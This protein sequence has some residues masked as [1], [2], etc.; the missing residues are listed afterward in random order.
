MANKYTTV[1]G[2]GLKDGTTWANAFGLAEYLVDFLNS[3][4]PGDIYYVF[5]G[6]YTMS[7]FNWT[8][9]DGNA[10]DFIK[11]VG[12]SD[13]TLLTE[14]QGDD[15]PL[16]DMGAF[17]MLFDDYWEIRNIRATGSNSAY[18][19]RGDTYATFVNCK[20][21]NTGLGE[22]FEGGAVFLRLI[23][24]EASVDGAT[25]SVSLGGN[26]GFFWGNYFHDSTT[27]LDAVSRD[28]SIFL[29]NIF[30]TCT[31]GLDL[32][33]TSTN[34]LIQNNTF[35]NCTTGLSMQT[36]TGSIVTNNNFDSNTTGVTNTAN[37]ATI[38]VDCNNYFNNGTDATNVTKGIN[39]TA[40][41]SNFTDAPNGDFSLGSAMAAGGCPSV[42][43]GGLST[44]YMEQGAVQRQNSTVTTVPTFAGISQ[45]ESVAYA[46]LKATWSAATDKTGYKIYVK[47]SNDTDLFTGTNLKCEIDADS[48]SFKFRIQTDN[49]SYLDSSI[50]YYVGVRATNSGTDDTNEVTLCATIS[51]GGDVGATFEYDEVVVQG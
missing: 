5:S 21:H 10:T 8:A 15:R 3:A 47:A 35:Y 23:L 19:W 2:A 40:V 13:Q 27:G 38:Y 39:A 42:F 33:G 29:F 12:V 6:T 41:D 48:T 11:I 28:T 31:L 26:G 7:A 4:S 46:C 34:N 45:L 18:T 37:D 22:A 9:R 30:D 44:S 32:T 1:A 25:A 50:V 43:P 17:S 36:S 49:D 16:F 51:G 24:C 20:A 14:A